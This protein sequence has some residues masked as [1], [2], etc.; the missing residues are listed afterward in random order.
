MLTINIETAR[1][2]ILGKQGLWP[3]RRWRGTAGTEAAMR[4]MEYL[5]LDPLHIL[6]R[7]QDITLHSRVLDYAP[8][9][10]EDLAYQQ[11]QFF[12][13]G[14]WLAVR[15]MD[16]LPHW[17]V[18]MRRERD[19]NSRIRNM[20]VE[21]TE[22][23]EEM[24]AILRERGTVSNR[25]FAMASRKR[26]QSYRGRKDSALA[27]YY[28]WRTGEVMTHHRKNFER[29]YALADTVAPAHLLRESDEAEADCFLIKKDVSFSGL[30]RPSRVAESFRGYGESDRATKKLLGAM[31]ADGDLIKVQ[32]EGWKAVHYALGSDAEV[33]RELSAGRVPKDWTPIETTTTD[34]VVFLAPLEHVSA[35]GRAKEVFGFDYIWEVYK[36][37]HQRRFGYYTLP[38]LWGDRLVARFDSKLDRT[39][40]TFV[41]LGLWLEEEALGADEAF[42]QALACGFARF[43]RFLGANKLDATAIRELLRQRV[44]SSLEAN[45]GEAQSR[46]RK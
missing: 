25:D 23:I 31:V 38:V 33:L 11:R 19:G 46:E 29:V 2:F 45:A 22:A 8:G 20:A 36:P 30:S 16:E 28:L 39:T 3:G 7:S 5:Q 32:V 10:W 1:R 9:M 13:W 15:P 42:A 24:R 26:T 34:E 14:G 17:R 12:D 43:V 44:C 40:N 6:A 41:I 37:E 4:A 27:L 18:V 21:H 35:R